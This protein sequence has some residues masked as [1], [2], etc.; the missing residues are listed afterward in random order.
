MEEE[1][2]FPCFIKASRSGSSVGCYRCDH[3]ED[4]M[5]KLIEASK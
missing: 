4:L 2:G 5:T 1:L 3:K